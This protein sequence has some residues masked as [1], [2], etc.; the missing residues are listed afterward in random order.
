VFWLVQLNAV[1]LDVDVDPAAVLGA[2]TVVVAVIVDVVVGELK[3]G[4]AV[5]ASAKSV[6]LAHLNPSPLAQHDATFSA[7]PQQLFPSPQCE[8]G[9]A[10][11]TVARET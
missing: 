5:C 2:K 10:S 8:M 1:G 4:V 7:V 3:T 11:P 9:A 6:A